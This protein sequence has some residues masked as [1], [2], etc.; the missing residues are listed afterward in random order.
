MG[1]PQSRPRPATHTFATGGTYAI[2]RHGHRCVRA[3]LVGQQDRD[4]GGIECLAR[5]LQRLDDEVVEPEREDQLL[6]R[7]D[8]GGRARRRRATD[9]GRRRYRGVDRRGGEDV[10][11]RDR[12]GTGTC[13]LKSGTLGY[14]RT[15]V[16]PER[17]RGRPRPTA[18][19]DPA[20]NHNQSG[21]RT[22]T[23]TLIRP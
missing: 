20:S 11:L 8:Y 19:Y 6:E 15:T 1:R 3:V 17:D 23:F 7:H 22:T 2:T 14:G 16:H 5:R 12:C 4:R 10:D 18:S 13:V 21:A 9:C